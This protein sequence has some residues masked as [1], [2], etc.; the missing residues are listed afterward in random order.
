[1][2]DQD[3]K[4]KGKTSL[5]GQYDRDSEDVTQSHMGQHHLKSV[6]DREAFAARNQEDDEDTREAR[7]VPATNQG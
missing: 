7:S 6:E 5:P 3:D 2:P 1:M 4:N